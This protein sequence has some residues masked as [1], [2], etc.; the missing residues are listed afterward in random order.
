MA[1]MTSITG[2]IFES[3]CRALVNPVNCVGVMGAGLA[4]QFRTQYPLMYRQ[5]QA[6][7][8]SGTVRIGHVTLYHAT[9]GR[10]IIN[11]PTKVHWRTPSLLD[12]IEKGLKH[13]REALSVNG[14]ESIAVPALGSGL[15]QLDWT[16]VRPMITRHLDLPGLQVEIYEPARLR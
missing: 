5:Y 14:I 10:T 1:T 12:H 9:D 6:D 13:L 15:G 4:R 7:C 2:N 16:A 8:R 3:E 11:F